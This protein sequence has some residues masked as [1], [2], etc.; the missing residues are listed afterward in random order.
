M[1]SAAI[2]SFHEN[3]LRTKASVNSKMEKLNVSLGGLQSCHPILN[4]ISSAR[5]VMK[6]KAQLKLLAGDLNL[7]GSIGD[8]INRSLSCL[9]CPS[10]EDEA[11]LFGISG[12]AAYKDTRERIIADIQSAAS[13]CSPPL[14]LCFEDDIKF[15]QFIADP[16]SF[17][18]DHSHRVNLNNHE[19]C[20]RMFKVCRDFIFAMLNIRKAHQAS[21]K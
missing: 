19:D 16:S 17:N 13:Q 11:H 9:F 15:I 20:D 14:K 4:H 18:L 3:E 12:C 7:N 5:E 6:V 21:N 1:C 8:N 2:L 10:I